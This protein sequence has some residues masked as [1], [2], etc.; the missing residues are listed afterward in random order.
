M[1]PFGGGT[2]KIEQEV[3]R[4]FSAARPVRMDVDTTARKGAHARIIE[5]FSRGEY[6]VLIGTQM[7]A[8]GLHFP[9]VTLVGRRLG[10][11]RPQSARLPGRRAHVPDPLPSGRAGRAEAEKGE[12]W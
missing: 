12:K 5:A 9:G 2:Q 7:V 10:R 1:R 4:V 11:R 8:K 3:R 6:N